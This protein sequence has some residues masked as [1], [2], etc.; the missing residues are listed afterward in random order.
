MN[1]FLKDLEKEL[2]KLNINAND[3]NE[4]IEDHKEMIE[5]AKNDGLD[6]LQVEKKFGN[7]KSI[8]EEIYKDNKETASNISMNLDSI[9]SCV[10]E[11]TEDYDYIKGFPVIPNNVSINIW[12]V[13]ES[14]A[15]T[16][17]DGQGIQ[18]Y[19]RNIKDLK[20]YNI[21]LINDKFILERR[22]KSSVNL[23]EFRRKSPNFLVLVPASFKFDEF[24]YSFISGDTRINEI[25]AKIFNLKSTSGDVEMT[26]ID[27]DEFK[28]STVSGDL[29]L[30]RFNG[31][32]FEISSVSGDLEIKSGAINEKM[33]FH[34]VS[35]DIN[36]ENLVCNE[37][38][39]KTVSGDLEGKEFY[40]NQISLKS[41]SGD[42][43]IT[44]HDKTKEI[45]VLSQKS[46]SGKINF[47]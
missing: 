15:I 14:L 16:T 34:S 30:T 26:N 28:G 36:I 47:K 4:I 2:K 31:K 17:Y 5:T 37:A 12:L 43:V 13:N 41:V 8:A 23:F 11:K 32:S 27:F 42:I 33:F 20:N 25:N 24:K 9:D 39:F 1:K 40:P 6:D 29:N 38:I 22:K 3:I 44:N 45:L 18:V 46:V 35:G 21:E 7:P 10:K 19:Q